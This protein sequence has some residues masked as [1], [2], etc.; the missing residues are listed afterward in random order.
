M[1]VCSFQSSGQIREW[2]AALISTPYE[3]RLNF[4]LSLSSYLFLSP[5]LFSHSL[6]RDL[7]SFL[8]SLLSFPVF[9]SVSLTL[10]FDVSSHVSPPHCL[11]H[12]YP[13]LIFD[14]S[15]RCLFWRCCLEWIVKREQLAF[16]RLKR[17][18]DAWDGGLDLLRGCRYRMWLAASTATA[19]LT[20]QFWADLFNRQPVFPTF[21]LPL[22]YFHISN[23]S[24][25]VTM[26]RFSH[27]YIIIIK[28][29]I[30]F[31]EHFLSS[32]KFPNNNRAMVTLKNGCKS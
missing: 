25:K 27:V 2:P 8:L 13:H 30:L 16:H 26:N 6:A 19:P 9:L 23:A 28:V 22:L 7:R 5:F 11:P 15:L 3:Q 14:S 12:F 21:F 18:S 1:C 20:L 31:I 24:H 17:P 29:I 10:T 4:S 32:E